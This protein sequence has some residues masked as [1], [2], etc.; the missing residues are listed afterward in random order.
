MITIQKTFITYDIRN[1]ELT[2]TEITKYVDEEMS[3]VSRSPQLVYDEWEL[4]NYA[5]EFA[6]DLYREA[7]HPDG[8]YYDEEV[9]ADNLDGYEIEELEQFILDYLMDN[10]PHAE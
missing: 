8:D 3:R 4:E 9:E 6:L 1:I 5:R 7:D 2:E 10:Y